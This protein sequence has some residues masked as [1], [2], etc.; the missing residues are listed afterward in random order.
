[1]CQQTDGRIYYLLVMSCWDDQ[2][3]CPRGYE[4]CDMNTNGMCKIQVMTES[5]IPRIKELFK[6]DVERFLEIS[7]FSV[8]VI[9]PEKEAYIVSARKDFSDS[10]CKQG[11]HKYDNALCPLMY[12]N[13]DFYTWAEGYVKLHQKEIAN[14]KKV[15][16]LNNGTVFVRRIKSHT[17][18]YCVATEKEDPIMKTIFVNHANSILQLGDYCY[19]ELISNSSALLCQFSFPKIEIFKP[20]LDREIPCLA[21]YEALR[22]EKMIEVIKNNDVKKYDIPLKL[23]VDNTKN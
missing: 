13:L 16:G 17:L 11:F 19:N 22:R 15:Y 1:M 6:S 20:F 23:V 14:V 3:N 5:H 18:L 2:L 9:T 21:G 10:Y 12:E 7:H 4:V 8:I